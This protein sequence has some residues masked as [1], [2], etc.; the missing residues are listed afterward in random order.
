M[1]PEIRG[2]T[3]GPLNCIKI[4]LAK[5]GEEFYKLKVLTI[6]G[7]DDKQTKEVTQG[8]M[9][10]HN[11]YLLL[12]NLKGLEGI[13]RCYGMII[14]YVQD[15][16]MKKMRRITLVLDP[17]SDKSVENWMNINMVNYNISLQEYISRHKMT[18]REGA[19]LVINLICNFIA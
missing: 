2:N 14:D 4:Y 19:H 18:E 7:Q 10:F 15:E 9:L 8:K 5:K 16:K 17:L 11:E 13:E 1:G 6:E 3:A 12:E